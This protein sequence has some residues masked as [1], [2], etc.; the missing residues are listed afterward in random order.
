M[1]MQPVE[2]P[3]PPTVHGRWPRR[4]VLTKNFQATIFMG[5]EALLCAGNGRWTFEKSCA[6]WGRDPLEKRWT[7]LIQMGIMNLEIAVGLRTKSNVTTA[8]T[9]GTSY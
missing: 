9:T 8:E 3:L 6:T 2:I 7:E 5:V 1:E 4:G